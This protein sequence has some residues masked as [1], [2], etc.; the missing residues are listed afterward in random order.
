MSHHKTNKD[1]SQARNPAMRAAMGAMQRAAE[2]ARQTAIQTDTAIVVVREG[3]PVRITAEQ[4]RQERD[5][6]QPGKP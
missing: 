4:L 1:I 5:A 3:K 2:Q 6:K